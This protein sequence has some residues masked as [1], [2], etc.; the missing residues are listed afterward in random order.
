MKKGF[1]SHQL[2]HLI[3]TTKKRKSHTPRQI[4]SFGKHV[5]CMHF[6]DDMGF[7]LTLVILP[8]FPDE[9]QDIYFSI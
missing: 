6:S 2:P 5:K 4:L 3:F 1:G 8:F 9:N 7:L